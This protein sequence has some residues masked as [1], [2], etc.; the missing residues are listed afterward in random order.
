MRTVTTLLLGVALGALLTW[1][2]GSSRPLGDQADDGRKD[3]AAG[4]DPA[5]PA[6]QVQSPLPSAAAGLG[7]WSEGV[8]VWSTSTESQR[9]VIRGFRDVEVIDRKL[10]ATTGQ[11]SSVTHYG[12]ASFSVRDGAS[13]GE[14]QLC[15]AGFAAD[16]DFVLE[17]W[18]LV[19][20]AATSS[21]GGP[22]AQVL[23]QDGLPLK[24]MRKTEICRGPVAD[25]L[26]GI[27]FDAEGRY[28]MAHVVLQSQHLLYRFDNQE[29]TDPVVVMDAYSLPELPL[30][31]TM[32]K[33]H[34]STYGRVLLL[35]DAPGGDYGIRVALVDPDNDGHFDAPPMVGD[36]AYFMAAGFYDPGAWVSLVGP[37]GSS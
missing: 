30:M 6:A 8:P 11:W 2:V 17:R 28:I 9:F 3:P 15:F 18:S 20:V 5:P 33:A 34:S 14:D 37:E 1:V 22:S 7:S 10:N 21:T 24:R 36:R 26:R 35:D 29:N 4:V 16:G 19:P 32:V 13:A 12:S 31:T 25:E 27:E 23:N